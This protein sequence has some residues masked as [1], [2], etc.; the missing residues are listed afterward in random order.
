MQGTLN[1]LTHVKTHDLF[2]SAYLLSN[3]GRLTATHVAMDG[4]RRVS[5]E[6]QSPK[7]GELS[8][9]YLSGEAT[10]NLRELKASLNHLKQIIFQ[11]RPKP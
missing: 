3:G 9:E 10:V 7:L 1:G 5:F 6:F 2:Y 11:E 8:Q 4:S